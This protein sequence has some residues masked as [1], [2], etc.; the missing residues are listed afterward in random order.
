MTHPQRTRH[1]TR[2]GVMGGTFDPIHIGHLAIAE[3]ARVRLS[4]DGVLFVPARESP[5]KVGNTHATGDD[6]YRMVE[7]AIADNACFRASRLELDRRG[8]SYTVHTLEALRAAHGSDVALHFIMGMD[9]LETLP[10][11]RRPDDI[12]RLARLVV[13]ARPGYEADWDA[14]DRAVPGLRQATEVIDTLRLDLSSTE[15]RERV[16]RGMPVRYLV[17]APVEAYIR[18][19]RLYVGEGDAR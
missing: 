2:L 1:P 8:P 7:L 5:L 6:R 16:R 17:P 19:H 13:I 18:E 3:E 12:V 14:L 10:H 15:L 4:L 9:A 11:W